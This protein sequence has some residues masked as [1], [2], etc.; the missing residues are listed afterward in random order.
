MWQADRSDLQV[1]PTIFL[2][3]IVVIVAVLTSYGGFSHAFAS[4]ASIKGAAAAS[5]YSSLPPASVPA[6]LTLFLGSAFAL[7]LYPHI[8]NGSLAANS[9][10]NLRRSLSLLPI[11]SIGLALLALFGIIIYAVPSALAIVKAAG[12]G[13]LV[14][15]SLVV[16]VLPGWLAGI[17]LL[18]I[19]IGGMV[20]AALMAIA[21]A[22]LLSRNVIKEFKPNI[23]PKDETT[24]AKW[25][26][27][28]IKFVALGFVFIAPLTY[29]I[30]LQLLGGIIILQLLPAIFLGLYMKDLDWKPLTLGWAAGLIS[31]IW[32]VLLANHFGPLA[33]SDVST[34]IGLLYIGLISLAVNM[35]I[36]LVGSAFVNVIGSRRSGLLKESDLVESKKLSKA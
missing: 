30:Q 24:I 22:N 7:Y 14:V 19:F 8:I 23:T 26:S 1:V 25:L 18:G 12:N 36:S 27:A 20:P 31:G 17:C 6:F 32:L 16:S 2:T 4:I 13:L 35:V 10:K 3:V 28:A 34:G 33:T 11:Y 29:A 15:P 9:K 5:P 21:A